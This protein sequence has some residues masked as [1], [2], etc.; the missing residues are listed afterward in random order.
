M[1]TYL[2]AIEASM[3][4]W[5]YYISKMKFADVVDRVKLAEE[6]H[7]A[8]ELDKV[9]QR[10]LS[11]RVVEMKEFLLQNPQRF[12]GAIVVAV[13]GG[14]PKFH[15]VKINEGNPII[16][17]VDNSFGLLKMDG[18]QQ[19]FALDGQHRVASIKAACE[20]DRDLLTDEISVIILKHENTADGLQRTRRLFT[21]LNRYAKTTTK[22]DDIA[23]DEDDVVAIITRRLIRDNSHFKNKIKIEGNSLNSKANKDKKYFTVMRILY[24]CNQLLL[25]AFNSRIDINKKF[26]SNRPKDELID[27]MYSYCAAIW[28]LLFSEIEQLKSISD[29]LYL[30]GVL[31]TGDNGGDIWG[32]PIIHKVVAGV[33]SQGLNEDKKSLISIVE[34]LQTLP[35]T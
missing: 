5:T 29:G 7:A 16:D 9:I 30:P 14:N 1:T 26:K 3:G 31:R 20:E 22:S 17:E 15:P 35:Q 12:Y 19:F 8:P 25:E 13:Y 23:I 6:I 28:T 10:K 21:K 18:T 27:D 34:K 11:D 32:R 2:E 33:I 4:D 24:D